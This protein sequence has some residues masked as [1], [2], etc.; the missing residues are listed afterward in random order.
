MQFIYTE[1]R[2]STAIVSSSQIYCS[3]GPKIEIDKSEI[4]GLRQLGYSWTKIAQQIGV[5]RRTL[6]NWRQSEA[7][8]NPL[9]NIADEQLDEFVEANRQTHRGERYT[10]GMI[11]AAG[12]TVPRRRLRES[13]FRVDPEGRELRRQREIKRRDY[14]V[15]GPHHLWHIDGHHKLIAASWVAA[16]TQSLLVAHCCAF[17]RLQILI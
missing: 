15:P 7:Y 17:D 12:F 6:F 16:F 4:D 9:A 14:F 2:F 13:I 10:W 3:M 11:R 1:H 5:K 8:E